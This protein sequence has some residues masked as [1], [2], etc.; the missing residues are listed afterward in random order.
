MNTLPLCSHSSASLI[1]CS[2][3]ISTILASKLDTPGS[4]DHHVI[5]Y[6]AMLYG[7]TSLNDLRNHL[8]AFICLLQLCSMYPNMAISRD[9]LPSFVQYPSSIFIC[10]QLSQCQP[11]LEQ[12]VVKCTSMALLEYLNTKRTTFHSPAQQDPCIFWFL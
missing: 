12:L 1:H 7:I 3:L 4:C 6:D 8:M 2:L 5:H 9:T 11:Q 10:F